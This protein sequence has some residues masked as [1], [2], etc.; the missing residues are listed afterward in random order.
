MPIRPTMKEDLHGSLFAYCL[1]CKMLKINVYNVTMGSENTY[2]C[3]V[4]IKFA[5]SSQNCVTAA[6]AT[7]KLTTSVRRLYLH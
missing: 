6:Y 2:V 4:H 1:M 3:Y 7:I 5:A